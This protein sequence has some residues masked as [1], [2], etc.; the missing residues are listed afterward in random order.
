M[1]YSNFYLIK[2][3]SIGYKKV[4]HAIFKKKDEL[5]FLNLV[6]IRVAHPFLSNFNKIFS[7]RFFFP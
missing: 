2:K 7:L 4:V 6:K 1:S 3:K 5:L